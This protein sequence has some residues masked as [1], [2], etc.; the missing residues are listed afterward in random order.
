MI[1]ILMYTFYG[2]LLCFYVFQCHIN[3]K[4]IKRD[5]N[6]E[7]KNSLLFIVIRSLE[8]IQVVDI[9][10]FV[11]R[12]DLISILFNSNSSNFLLNI[13]FEKKYLVKISKNF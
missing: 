9:F 4:N 3:E 6:E 11:F 2:L 13:Y 10:T 5:L 8:S 7:C 12:L 1:H